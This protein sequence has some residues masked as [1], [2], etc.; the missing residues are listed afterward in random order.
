VFHQK[1]LSHP[2][3]L[4]AAYN[5]FRNRQRPDLL[6]AVPECE[7]VP[8]FLVT[9]GWSFEYSLR[10]CQATP[11]GFDERAA[12]EGA[13]FNGF[14]LFQIIPQRRAVGSDVTRI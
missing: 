11:P 6:C 13:R 9:E 7:P 12:N 3:A 8:G 14:Y 2:V 1:Q 4:S 10:E 5:F